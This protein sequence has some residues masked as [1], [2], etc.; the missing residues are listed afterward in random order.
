MKSLLVHGPKHC[1]KVQGDKASVGNASTK[2]ITRAFPVAAM[3]G[4]EECGALCK[5]FSFNLQLFCIVFG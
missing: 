4:A 1:Q 3:S 2:H 5:D